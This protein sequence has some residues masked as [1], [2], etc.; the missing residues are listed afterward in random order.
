[1]GYTAMELQNIMPEFAAKLGELEE[2]CAK[3]GLQIKFSC[4]Y[5]SV[6]EQNE[7]YAQGRTKP[8]QKVTNAK[9]GNSQHNWGIAADFYRND[10]M[11]AYNELDN[12][13][14]RVG[15]IAMNI[16]L[17]WGGTWSGF[18]D[19]PHIYWDE[20][21][22]GTDKLKWKY[23]TPEKFMATWGVDG[24]W[25]AT[26]NAVPYEYGLKDFVKDI[27]R[28][29][30]AKVDGIAGNETLGKTPTLSVMQNKTHPAVK[31]VQKRLNYLG[32]ACGK[33]DGIFGKN[34]KSGVMS[35]QRYIGF[36]NP[37]GVMDA[38]NRTWKNILK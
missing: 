1:M 19:R 29:C 28:T 10:G 21:G 30:G 13:F 26:T 22:S 2:R 14:E 20:W 27:Q 3:A 9:G 15:E 8:G 36:R 38:G 7:L 6:E 32:F 17:G 5:R 31:Y 4:G 25:S 23:D 33:V 34:T 11:G 35:F 18:K 24:T 12:F 37:D 16:G